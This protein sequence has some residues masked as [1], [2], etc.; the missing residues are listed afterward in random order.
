M[1]WLKHYTFSCKW[2]KYSFEE[3]NKI[4]GGVISWMVME[5][6]IF[7]NTF[8]GQMNCD[9]WAKGVI[10]LA[11]LRYMF[12]SVLTAESWSITRITR[13]MPIIAE[14]TSQ[15]FSRGLVGRVNFFE[16]SLKQACQT[17]SPWA[18]CSPLQLMITHL[19]HCFYSACLY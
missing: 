8:D 16:F 10:S 3:I 12:T 14:I 2:Q 9:G 11:S 13:K 5:A 1:Y 18:A 19:F 17:C 15:Q 4:G 7:F 6:L